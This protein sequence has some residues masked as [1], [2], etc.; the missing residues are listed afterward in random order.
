MLK[1]KDLCLEVTKYEEDTIKNKNIIR[2]SLL[3]R[4][5][6]SSC[7]F[8]PRKDGYAWRC[9]RKGCQSVLSIR[10]G[11]FFSGSHLNLNEIV[12]IS[13]WWARGMNVTNVMHETGH[14]KQTIVD[15]FN[16]HR[17]VC[18]QY[19]IDNPVMLGGPGKIVEIDE[20]KFGKKKYN[21]GRY[22]EGHWELLSFQTNGE[23]TITWT[24]PQ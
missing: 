2:R 14:T 8:V 15:W 19:F 4:K 18:A 10:D 9:T 24:V 20:S 23:L 21:R 3:C 16:F 12:E 5:C 7:N 1:F 22:K 6:S 11:T 13:Y 17:D